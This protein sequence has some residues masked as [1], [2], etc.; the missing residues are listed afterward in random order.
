[1]AVVIADFF[2]DALLPSRVQY[3]TAAP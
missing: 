3:T 1:M 2:N